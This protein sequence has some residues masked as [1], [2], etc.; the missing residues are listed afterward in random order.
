MTSR[1][2][3]AG[4]PNAS[5]AAGVRR[6]HLVQ[7][8]GL[9]G[10]PLL[11]AGLVA[12]LLLASP[13]GASWRL[14]TAAVD[15]ASSPRLVA[16]S[17]SAPCSPLLLPTAGGPYGNATAV[18]PSGR[19]TVGIADD[20][21]G[22]SQPVLWR[23][24]SV[25]RLKT[26]LPGSIPV[27]VNDSGQV[28]GSAPKAATEGTQGWYWS[29]GRTALL[30]VP[31]DTGAVPEAISAT[32]RI[33]GALVPNEDVEDTS[34]ADG[35]AQA[36]TW[37]SP[38]SAP[39][40]LEPLAGAAGA[41][42]FT[43]NDSGSVA[44]IS[45]NSATTPV[46]WG[47]DGRPRALQELGGGW[48]VVRGLDDS[49]AAVG[50][51][52]LPDGTDRAVRWDDQGRAKDLGAAVGGP[53]SLAQSISESGVV[54]GRAR[55][56]NPRQGYRSHAIRWN[57]A[58][59]PQILPPASTTVGPGTAAIAEGMTRAGDVVGYTTDALDGRHPTEWRCRG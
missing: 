22:H 3:G 33:A 45:F 55:M 46:I 13:L 31:S 58:G 4:S 41:H 32:A 34:A 39:T 28:V 24:G 1:R 8:F 40:L 59:S 51:A 17:S 38:T 9:R 18:S 53:G 12:A 52:A 26:H 11:V 21:A 35:S 20:A 47:G 57:A 44:G 42:A 2:Q 16:A 15:A 19:Y 27:A 56:G 14:N 10:K 6:L 7:R 5:T 30:P 48:G 23:N 37:R 29:N 54:V 43:I 36:A 25:I 49:G 50:D